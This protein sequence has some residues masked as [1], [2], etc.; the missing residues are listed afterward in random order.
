M[1]AGNFRYGKTIMITDLMYK[2]SSNSRGMT[3]IQYGLDEITVI[4]INSFKGT[5]KAQKFFDAVEHLKRNVMPDLATE[6][7]VTNHFWVSFVFLT[8]DHHPYFVLV[9]RDF[10]EQFAEAIRGVDKMAT[11]PI[12]RYEANAQKIYIYLHMQ[13][14]C[15]FSNLH[16]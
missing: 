13:Y 11:R 1:L 4:D 14:T 9:E 15:V 3:N 10:A 16:E 12:Y 6:E 5:S 8:A 2:C 7:N